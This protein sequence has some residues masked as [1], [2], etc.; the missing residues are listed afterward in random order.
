MLAEEGYEVVGQAG[1]GQ[2][3]IELAESC[4]PTW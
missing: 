3:A 2:Q 1:D 4:G